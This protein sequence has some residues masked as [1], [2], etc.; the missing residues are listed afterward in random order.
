M[1]YRHLGKYGLQVSEIA[2]GSWMTQLEDQEKID[3]AE[4][5]IRKAYESGVNFFDCADGYNGGKS[6][7]FLGRVLKD[8]PRESYVVSSKVFFPVG[9]SVTECGLSRKHISDSIDNSLR[10][11]GM[12]YLDL[13]FCHRPDP[14]TPM[15]ETLAT[16]SKLVDDGKILYYGV[17]EWTPAQIERA[18]GITKYM[19]L[20]PISV[21][22]PEYNMVDRYI[23]NEIIG[24]C[25]REGIGIT[26]F[27]PL[28]Q[29]LLTGKYKKGQDI[30][31]GSR[32]TFQADRQINNMLTDE[33]LGKVEKLSAI[34]EAIGITMAQLALAWIL[35]RDE[36][37]CVIAGASRVSQLESNLKAGDVVLSKDVLDE[38]DE[39]L[40]YHPVFRHIG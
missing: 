27:S 12:D 33:N 6:E 8:Y 38:I 2:V 40:D 11:M 28:S 30:P 23:E 35:R 31:A 39:I 21:I 32:A 14:E 4:E 18:I 36:I 7:E 34:A 9:P 19:H 29:G 20:H 24:I 15:E 16:L 17:S 5:V 37:T 22:Q 13:Y 26:V 10:K 25:K 3:R 1:K